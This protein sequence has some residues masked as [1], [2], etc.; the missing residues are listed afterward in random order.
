[1]R[2]LGL[3]VENDMFKEHSW[4]FRNALVRANY[5]NMPKGIDPDTSYLILFFR[6]LLL[7]E[8]NVLKNRDL[9]ISA[10]ELPP[11]CL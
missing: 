9:H 5:R 3:Q 10:D 7:G 8:N 4:Y 2:T 11:T 1:M 6:N